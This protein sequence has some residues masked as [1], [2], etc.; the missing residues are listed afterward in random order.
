MQDIEAKLERE[1]DAGLVACQEEVMGFMR[2]VEALTQAQVHSHFPAEASALLCTLSRSPHS[3][4]HASH[5]SLF[6]AVQHKH[7]DRVE[8]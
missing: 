6:V 5:A 8:I 1:L 7:T 2:P 3:Y 4:L